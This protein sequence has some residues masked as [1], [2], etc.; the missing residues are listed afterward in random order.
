MRWAISAELVK[1]VGFVDYSYRDSRC[2]AVVVV[3]GGE[4]LPWRDARD[5]L[6]GC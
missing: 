6:G 4:A 3:A 1:A 5:L 2:F